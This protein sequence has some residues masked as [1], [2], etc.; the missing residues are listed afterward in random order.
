MEPPDRPRRR[1]PEV[2]AYVVTQRP[3]PVND[4]T[5][6]TGG[7]KGPSYSVPWDEVDPAETAQQ[8]KKLGDET[9]AKATAETFL[10][11][12]GLLASDLLPSTVQVGSSF[13]V[14]G[15]GSTD[16]P[17]IT[18]W[19]V[20]YAQRGP[21]GAELQN[22]GVSVRVAGVGVV[23][24]GWSL[25]DFR[26]DGVVPLRPFAEVIADQHAWTAGSTSRG[27]GVGDSAIRLT[28]TGARLGWTLIPDP[29]ADDQA[30]HFLIPLYIVD[31]TVTDPAAPATAAKGQWYLPA[32]A[33]V[34]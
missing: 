3:L 12:H 22:A 23:Q 2:P 24:V 32:A 11:D 34:E 29:A 25:R 5:W 16:G 10:R 27:L 26:A 15:G 1:H 30:G 4:L 13:S 31:V 9:K 21:D 18:S 8:A 33:K 14:S 17:T 28:I 20:D 6:S 7:P 19:L